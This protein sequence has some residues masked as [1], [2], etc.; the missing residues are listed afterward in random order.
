ML[1]GAVPGLLGQS[2]DSKDLLLKKLT[3][4]FAPTKLTADRSDVVKAG[5]IVALQKDGLLVYTVTV[6]S[7]PISVYKNGKL[8]QGFGDALKVDMV[9][10][11]GRDGGS[12]SIPR[13]TLVA[14][15]KF[16]VNAIEIGKDA[17]FV[18]IV[19]DPYDDGRY[20]GILKFLAPK[21]VFPSPDDAVKMV[22][23]VLQAQQA[24]E[25]ASQPAPA[26][27]PASLPA[28]PPPAA[29]QDVPPP[30]PAPG[31]APTVSLGMTREQVV[32]AFGE[33]E[34]KAALGPK[35]IFIYSELKMKVTFTNGK[36]TNVE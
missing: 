7:A 30:P 3:A 19:T 33:P 23:E 21:G 25:Q 22:S 4:Q 29:Y 11:M 6:P 17:I 36:V 35:Q 9:D 34:R 10:G 32:G 13:K 28:P 14:G 1:A 24:P 8:S 15:E 5:S 31:P 2:G 26:P 27:A 18:Q 20:Y 12:A 16:W